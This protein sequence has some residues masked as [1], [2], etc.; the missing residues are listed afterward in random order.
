MGH[1][2]T[3]PRM[4][5]AAEM[6]ATALKVLKTSEIEDIY[7]MCATEV[8]DAS[9]E[10]LFETT[11]MYYT[12]VRLNNTLDG[13]VRSVVS[14]LVASG[15]NVT[16]KSLV[17]HS[18]TNNK[19]TLTVNWEETV[20]PTSSCRFA[21]SSFPVL[22]SQSIVINGVGGGGCCVVPPCSAGNVSCGMSPCG[23]INVCVGGQ[24]F[25]GN[26]G[27]IGPQGFQGAQGPLGDVHPVINIRTSA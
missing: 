17:P 16:F 14:R 9:E 22:T 18:S 26:I 5:D 27:C 8:R 2:T 15:Y 1:E 25:Q 11:V 21:G 24:G 13:I 19:F 4:P 7:D 20:A 12:S 23:D 10:G 6:R 3:S